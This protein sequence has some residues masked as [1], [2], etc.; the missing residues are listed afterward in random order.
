MGLDL[1]KAKRLNRAPRFHECVSPFTLAGHVVA[2][3]SL[4]QLALVQVGEGDVRE[5]VAEDPLVSF[6]ECLPHAFGTTNQTR[7]SGARSSRRRATASR[8]RRVACVDN[9]EQ[10]D[11]MS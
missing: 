1:D 9:P 6:E 4:F 5:A 10:P 11:R 2:D 8:T 3:N 7:V